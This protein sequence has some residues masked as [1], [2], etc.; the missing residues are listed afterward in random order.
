M[1]KASI[2]KETWRG[3]QCQDLLSLLSSPNSFFA[4]SKLSSI[5]HRWPS[6]VTS[7]STDVPAGHQ[8]LNPPHSVQLPNRYPRQMAWKPLS[9]RPALSIRSAGDLGRRI[10]SPVTPLGL[11]KPRPLQYPMASTHGHLVLPPSWPVARQGTEDHRNRR[12]LAP[13][14]ASSPSLRVLA[15]GPAQ[16]IIS[17]LFTGCLQNDR[18]PSYRFYRALQQLKSSIRCICHIF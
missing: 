1:A 6:T 12:S 3:H 15:G 2:T 11:D 8:V 5:A 14:I 16:G 4:V 13:A 10:R 7:V 18:W 17:A 9:V